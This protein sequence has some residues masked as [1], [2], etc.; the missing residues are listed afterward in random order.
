MSAAADT[1]KLMLE[2]T[3]DEIRRAF[4]HLY[5][6]LV[7]CLGHEATVRTDM[8]VSSPVGVAIYHT[9]GRAEQ[10][11]YL[12]ERVRDASHRIA[13]SEQR[14]AHNARPTP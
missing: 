12:H 7:E 11:R 8:L 6:R 3:V 9:Q 14:R 10:A 1:D 5:D 2:R 13:A 4:P